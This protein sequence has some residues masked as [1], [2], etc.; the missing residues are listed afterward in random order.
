M[1]RYLPILLSVMV[2][3]G[4]A[5]WLVQYKHA[6]AT[7]HYT[8]PTPL[9]TNLLGHF[10]PTPSCAKPPAFLKALKIPQ[11][12]IIDL[13][14]KQYRGVALRFGKGFTQVLH[15][16]QWEQYGHFSTYALDRSGDLYLIP[17]PFISIEPSTFAWQRQLYRLDT[18]TGRLAPFMAFDSILPTANNPYG[19][20]AITYDCSDHSLWVARIDR[21][22]YQTQ[23]GILYHIDI[24]TQTI[25]QHIEGIDALSL[26]LLQS[27][28]GRFLLVGS[29]RDNHLYAYPL[30]QGEAHPPAIPL[31][32]LPRASEHI[33]KIRILSDSTLELQT[34]PFGYSLITQ[35]AQSDRAYYHAQWDPHLNKWA[36]H[37][38]NTH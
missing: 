16:K 3:T 33:R 27:T 15:P 10:A 9:P 11:P 28:R 36:I 8:T 29:A 2:V 18:K 23:K 13:S 14:Q 37:P 19:L 35:T 25:L 30:R 7:P 17:M 21:S 22:D 26:Q 32:T 38:Q 4:G 12:V 1:R 20:S 34:I 31:L 6:Q 24:A 5:W